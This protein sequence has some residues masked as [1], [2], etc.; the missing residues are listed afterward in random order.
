MILKRLAPLK[1]VVNYKIGGAAD[2]FFEFQSVEE[3]KQALTDYKEIDPSLSSVFV[4]GK[5]TNVLFGDNGYGGLVLKNSLSGIERMGDDVKVASGESVDDLLEFVINESLSGLEWAGGLPGTVGGAVRGNAGAF[6]GETK[7]NIIEVE[8][9]DIDS[10]QIKKRNNTECR[11]DYRQSVFKRGDGEREIILSA[12]FRLVSGNI[13]EIKSKTQEKVDYR[14]NRH[15]LDYPNIGSTFKNVP[16]EK[17]PEEVLEKFSASIKQD[18][19]PVLPV[20]KLIASTDLV[21]KRIGDAQISTKHPN[22]IVNLG[23]ATASDV[24]SII[25]L[26]KKEIKEKF[27]IDL[28]EEIMI[29][30]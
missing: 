15:P 3:L 9:L 21:G 22:F 12:E 1:D 14:I 30:N 10:L 6:L 18:P 20:A 29:V 11:F 4:L 8:S 17:V 26:V 5:G 16:V 23:N 19:F 2:Y 25:D 28:E 13:D 24:L 7:D 27:E